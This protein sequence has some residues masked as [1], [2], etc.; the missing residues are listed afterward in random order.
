MSDRADLSDEDQDIDIE[1]DVRLSIYSFNNRMHSNVDCN[2]IFRAILE[3]LSTWL[4]FYLF[5]L[6]FQED[7]TN[8]SLGG[9]QF[10]SE[11]S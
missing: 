11:V 10:A 2:C 7:D 4:G 6:F 1:S 3:F 8:S 9:N 5:L